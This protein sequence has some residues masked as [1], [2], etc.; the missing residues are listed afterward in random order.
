MTL[1][2][3]TEIICLP[4]LEIFSCCFTYLLAVALWQFLVFS[5]HIQYQWGYISSCI[6]HFKHLAAKMGSVPTPLT[7]SE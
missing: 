2:T 7:G 5:A 3:D 1:K 6:L 4:F